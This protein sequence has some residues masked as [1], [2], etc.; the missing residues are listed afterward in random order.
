MK[1]FNLQKSQNLNA[2]KNKVVLFD[3][4][5]KE[6][7][8]F[9]LF[10]IN[11]IDKLKIKKIIVLHH[12]NKEYICKYIYERNKVVKK[13]TLFNIN[14]LIQKKYFMEEADVLIMD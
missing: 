2:L 13:H 4:H 3:C 5:K 11:N 14:N 6:K 12:P 9:V 7:D 8:D 1:S 10:F